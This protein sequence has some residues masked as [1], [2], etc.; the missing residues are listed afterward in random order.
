MGKLIVIDGL[1]GSGKTTQFELIQKILSDRGISV[2]A[3]SFPEY[4]KPSSTL[5]KMYLGGE[6]SKNAEDVNAYASSSFYAVDRYASYKLYW[7]KDYLDDKLILASR[8]VSSN[9]I[10]QMV[11]LPE[12]EWEKY[13]EWLIDYE[14]IKMDIPKAD[15]IIFLDMPI[16]ISQKLLSQ[17]YNGDENKKDIHE[18]NVEYLHRCRKSALFAAEKLGWSVVTCNGGENPLPTE[19]ISKKIMKIIDEVI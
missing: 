15:K 16:E 17:R 11:K 18:S 9:A 8:Y 14:H 13:L 1:D 2:K 6:F 5:V 4:D 19:E 3:I 12:E 7:E 10:H